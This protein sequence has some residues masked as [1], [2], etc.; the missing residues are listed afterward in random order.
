MKV[1][2]NFLDST[3]LAYVKKS[4]LEFEMIWSYSDT[5]VSDTDTDLRS[6]QFYHLFCQF[7]HP[8][9]VIDYIKPI[10]KKMT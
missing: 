7:Y 2:D 10:G 8:S 4:I 6:T 3:E 9:R 1:V 5:K